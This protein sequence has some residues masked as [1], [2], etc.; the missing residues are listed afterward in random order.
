MPPAKYELFKE[1]TLIGKGDIPEDLSA[2]THV[3]PL[4][5]LLL[6]NP[7]DNGPVILENSTPKQTWQVPP[8]DVK[9]F[10]IKTSDRGGFT[11][12]VIHD[13]ETT[14]TIQLTS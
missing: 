10:K 14:E 3:N 13:P 2:P 5:D 4:Y 11:L 1:E 12:R 7:P 6:K 8:G 9:L